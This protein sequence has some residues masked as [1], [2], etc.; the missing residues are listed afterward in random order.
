MCPSKGRDTVDEKSPDSHAPAYHKR[1]T[2]V[3]AAL[4][5]LSAV[6]QHLE[7]VPGVT[8]V[9][10]ACGL[11]RLS[12]ETAREDLDLGEDTGGHDPVASRGL[13]ALAVGVRVADDELFHGVIL[14]SVERVDIS[15]VGPT[16]GNT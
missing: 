8:G 2:P 9:G 11:D 14:A 15:M 5:G 7:R 10:L 1:A 12:I 16:G 4:E 13:K 6:G 3:G